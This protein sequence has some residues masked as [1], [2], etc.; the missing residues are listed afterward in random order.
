LLSLVV[1]SGVLGVT[2]RVTKDVTKRLTQRLASA[3]LPI[4]DS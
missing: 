4:F 1:F 2:K 3:G